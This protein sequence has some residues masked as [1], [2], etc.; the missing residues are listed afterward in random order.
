MQTLHYGSKGATPVRM[1]GPLA[2]NMQLEEIELTAALQELVEA[3]SHPAIVGPP[4]HF[5]HS[6]INLWTGV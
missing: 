4:D 2:H 5:P 3:S 1:Q 6:G